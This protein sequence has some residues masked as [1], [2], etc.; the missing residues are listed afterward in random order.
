MGCPGGHHLDRAAHFSLQHSDPLRLRHGSRA[1]CG[2][3]LPQRLIA[4]T[5]GC[6][7]PARIRDIRRGARLVHA[8][9]PID[10]FARQRRPDDQVGKDSIAPPYKKKSEARRVAARTES[11]DPPGSAV[12]LAPLDAVRTARQAAAARGSRCLPPPTSA[13]GFPVPSMGATSLLRIDALGARS[14]PRAGGISP[15]GQGLVTIP[16]ECLSKTHCAHCGM[17][18]ASCAM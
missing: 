5:E 12:C 11:Q 15:S 13:L 8:T 6:Q 3:D 4:G 14:L 7:Q 16:V 2:P 18:R 17:T 9:Q 10:R 1:G